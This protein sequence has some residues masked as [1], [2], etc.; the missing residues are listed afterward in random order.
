MQ[1]RTSR[2][3]TNPF[4]PI[5]PEGEEPETYR[6]VSI[7]ISGICKRMLNDQSLDLFLTA[8]QAFRADGL[9]PVSAL[10][11]TGKRCSCLK[12]LSKRSRST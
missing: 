10:P 5:L 1:S 3:A 6:D 4:S 11:R 12:G 7:R 9:T 2:G 8:L